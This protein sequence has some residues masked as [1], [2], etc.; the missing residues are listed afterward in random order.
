[1]YHMRL[2]IISFIRSAW[3]IEIPISDVTCSASGSIAT[4]FP[5]PCAMKRAS[6]STLKYS[7]G[8]RNESAVCWTGAYA[9]AN[10]YLSARMH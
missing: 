7:C 2:K 1:M 9:L 5:S 4:A 10:C 8:A 3:S 6:V